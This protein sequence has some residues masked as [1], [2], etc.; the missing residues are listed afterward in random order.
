MLSIAEVAS[1]FDG[2][3]KRENG[4][5]VKCPCHDDRHASLSISEG[6]AGSILLH[7][8]TGVC[9]TEDILAA[10]GLNWSDICMEKEVHQYKAGKVEVAVYPYC[11]ED[12]TCRYERV[13][14]WDPENKRKE[15]RYRIRDQQTGEVQWSL[16]QAGVAKTLFRL[17]ELLEAVRKKEQIYYVEGEKD[18]LTMESHG[19]VATT[20]GAAD[21]WDSRYAGYFK[22]ADV[23]ILPDNDDVGKKSAEKVAKDLQGIAASIRMVMTSKADKGDVSDYFLEGHSKEDFIKLLDES[24]LISADTTSLPNVVEYPKTI[25]ADELQKMDIPPIRWFVDTLITAGLSLLVGPSKAGKSWFVLQMCHD[26]A[27]GAP[28]LNRETEQVKVLYL[29]LE[30]SPRRLKDRMVKQLAGK[31]AS[32]NLYFQTEAATLEIGLMEQLLR[33]VNAGVKVIF[34][35]TLQKVRTSNGRANAYAADYNDMGI[36]KKFADQYGVAVVLVHHTRKM[37]DDDV[38]NMISGTNGIMGAAD[39]IMIL[40][41]PDRMKSEAVLHITGRD[42]PSNELSLTFNNSTG[43]WEY[44]GEVEDLN[45]KMAEFNYR[46][47]PIVR[48]VNHL[49]DE[50]C[51]GWRG[52]ASDLLVEMMKLGYPPVEESTIG[53]FLKK[54]QEEFFRRDHIIYMPPSGNSNNNRQHTFRREHPH[55]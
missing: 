53:K 25:S 17:P 54:T 9:K 4:Y 18:V 20:A 3:V 1:R 48:T 21:D 32:P 2:I 15:F 13:R 28:F 37:K 34:I 42:A 12:G 41:K 5:Q 49:L 55:F 40:E 10:K 31:K 39:T 22:G 8:H 47:D 7:C 6:R 23:I 33:H 27:S 26:I 52:R 30:D 44:L 35:D 51:S 29:A 19:F 11:N 24:Q 38:F 16:K 50:N 46:H 43:R 36:L 45:E 14:Y